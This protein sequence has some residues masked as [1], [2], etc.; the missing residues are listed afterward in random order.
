MD[1]Q[2]LAAFATQLKGAPASIYVVMLGLDRRTGPNELV[3]YT[4]YSDHTIRTALRRLALMG[5]VRRCARYQGW[6]LTPHAHQQF[7][8]ILAPPEPVPEP[9]PRPQAAPE[10]EKTLPLPAPDLVADGSVDEAAD[11]D[12]DPA[13]SAEADGPANGEAE[14]QN[15]SVERKKMSVPCS[16]CSH[17]SS[18]SSSVSQDKPQ[19][20]HEQLT[21]TTTCG[22]DGQKLPLPAA[23]RSAPA[24]KP[25]GRPGRDRAPTGGLDPNWLPDAR[26]LGPEAEAAIA[27]LRACGCPS[28]SDPPWHG[29]RTV[30]ERALAH[31]W[32]GARILRV[33]E[34][35]FDYVDSPRGRGI[36]SKGF[37]TLSK[38]WVGEEPPPAPAAVPPRPTAWRA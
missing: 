33:A 16:S 19:T 8:Q 38:L 13:P 25:R 21:T 36:Q 22:P 29:A 34:A 20:H 31:G 30:V 35:W 28:R 9:A 1:P 2:A 11:A 5:L 27:K 26:R 18:Q 3:C 10:D 17:E 15:L 24:H 32:P 23:D 12:V 37:F 6:E 14:G 4:G 7:R